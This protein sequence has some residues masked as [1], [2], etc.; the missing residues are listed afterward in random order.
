MY[1]DL[2][3]IINGSAANASI[4]MLVLTGKEDFFCSGND[5]S[6]AM[7]SEIENPSQLF[8]YATQL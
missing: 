5:F 8:K 1:K 2:A 4:R 7:S 3:D 6:A